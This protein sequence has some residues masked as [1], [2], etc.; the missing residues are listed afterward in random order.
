MKSAT[1]VW[2]AARCMKRAALTPRTH[3]AKTGLL[4]PFGVKTRNRALTGP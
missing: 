4:P 1:V 2:S 3:L